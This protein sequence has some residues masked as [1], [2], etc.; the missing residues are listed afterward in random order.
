[1]IKHDLTNDGQNSIHSNKQQTGR[2]FLLQQSLIISQWI[3]KFDVKNINEF[4][5][6]K[7]VPTNIKA[8][9]RFSE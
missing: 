1:M 8:F 4:Y 7:E 5:E 2:T 9:Q 3:N 6:L